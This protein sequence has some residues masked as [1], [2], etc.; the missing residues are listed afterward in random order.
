[1]QNH[2]IDRV[3]RGKMPLSENVTRRLFDK[4]GKQKQLFQQNRIGNAIMRAA[5]AFVNPIEVVR[6]ESGFV[7]GSRV[8]AGWLNKIAA[9]GPQNLFSG[10]WV[11]EQKGANLI[12]NA[13][14][15]GVASRINGS[16]GEAAFTYVAIGTGTNAA[17]V[18][19]TTLQTE[20][21]TNGGQ[22][23]SATASRVTTDVTNDTA[24]LVVTF[25][26]TGS[27]AV[28]ESGV[29]NAASSGVLLNRQVF[30][31]VNVVSGDSLQ[32]THNF[33]VD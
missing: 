10:S 21:T 32:V 29:L 4:D 6:D 20:I 18:G 9:Y 8:K 28:T 26:F 22:R 31:A 23:A 24:R 13:G 25:T 3:L 30:S 33:D 1:M 12:T 5:R 11:W 19:D 2:T 14:A 27:F 16:G 17:A 15:A 7:I